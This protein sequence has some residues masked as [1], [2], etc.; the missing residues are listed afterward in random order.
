VN[1]KLAVFD[2]DGTVGD[3]FTPHPTAPGIDQACRQA[4]TAMFG[5]A[6]G[7][8]YDGVGGLKNRSPA[9]ITETVIKYGGATQLLQELRERID[10]FRAKLDTCVPAGKGV[11]LIWNEEDP[12]RVATEIFVRF[13]LSMFRIGRNTDGSIWPRPC[14][15]ILTFI[16]RLRQQDIE[17]GILSSGHEW[18]IKECFAL[19]EHECPVVMFTDD[20]IRGSSIPLSERSK[21]SPRLFDLFLERFGQEI[22][23]QNIVYYGDDIIKDGQLAYNSGVRFGWYNPTRIVI[24]PRVQTPYVTFNNW[25]ELICE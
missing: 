9:E 11:P 6:G 2:F 4:F 22:S 5:V 24:S 3:T 19:W 16:D 14:G 1:I 8:F 23:R 10:T 17:V 25:R 13:K 15:G 21:P 20:D 7:S 12:Y 18:F